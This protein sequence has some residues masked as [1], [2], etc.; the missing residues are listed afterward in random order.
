MTD[1][2]VQRWTVLSRTTDGDGHV[3]RGE[4]GYRRTAKP[5]EERRERV[6]RFESRLR[7]WLTWGWDGGSETPVSV[8]LFSVRTGRCIGNPNWLIHSGELKGLRKLARAAFPAE[9]K[10]KKPAAVPAETPP[11][12]ADG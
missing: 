8:E 9:P 3:K 4:A 1:V 11:A 7:V 12:C 10:K 2:R 5:Q 6:H